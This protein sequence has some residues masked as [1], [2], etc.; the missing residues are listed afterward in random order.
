[1]LKKCAQESVAEELRSL[2][3]DKPPKHEIQVQRE[4]DASAAASFAAAR[5]TQCTLSFAKTLSHARDQAAVSLC[6][7]DSQC[8][9]SHICIVWWMGRH[10]TAACT[11]WQLMRQREGSCLFRQVVRAKVHIAI[12][13]SDLVEACM[14]TC[15]QTRVRVDLPLSV[16]IPSPT[17]AFGALGSGCTCTVLECQLALQSA[18][19]VLWLLSQ[20][21]ARCSLSPQHAWYQCSLPYC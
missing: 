10:C 1:M 12:D 7:S 17:V 3:I 2:R 9:L 19:N 15:N 11:Y 21:F 14:G 8:E 16:C 20:V 13:T 5:A 18:G 6:R 4:E